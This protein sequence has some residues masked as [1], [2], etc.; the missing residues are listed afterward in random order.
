MKTPQLL[1]YARDCWIA[2]S[3]DLDVHNG[4]FAI[5]PEYPDGTYAYFATLDPSGNSFYPYLIGTSYFGVVA[6]DNLGAGSV[7]VPGDATLYVVPEPGSALAAGAACG[8][9]LLRRRPRRDRSLPLH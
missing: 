7:T 8:L 9:A 1:N 5:T 4:R 3:G 6:T 2:G